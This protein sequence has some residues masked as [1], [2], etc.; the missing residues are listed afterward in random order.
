MPITGG[1]TFKIDA[2]AF[3]RLLH[4]IGNRLD[5]DDKN[6]KRRITR[7]T[8]MI[9]RIAHQKRPY[10]SKAQ[11]KIEHRSKRVSD[12]NAQAGVPVQTGL[13]QSSIT[14]QVTRKG[15]M[16]YQGE[17]R[18][19]GVPYSG[20]IEYGTSKMRARPFMRPAVNLTKDAIQRM[21]KLHVESN[22]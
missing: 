14:Q 18:A 17:I 5:N 4:K 13:L 16:S 20:Y 7:A 15:L 9:W 11:M 10:I 8:E 22:L 6:I 1:Q 21:M 2:S 3:D 12:P 19:Y